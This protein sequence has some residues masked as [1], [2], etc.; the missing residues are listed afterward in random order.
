MATSSGGI[1]HLLALSIAQAASADVE[2]VVVPDEPE[3]WR[4][5]IAGTLDWG[6]GVGAEVLPH[7]EA[8]NLRPI[9]ALA[10]AR[11]PN[12]P[13][14]PTLTEA[15][16]PVSFNLWRG[17]MGPPALSEDD[18]AAWHKTIAAVR[19]TKAWRTYLQRNGQTDDFLAGEPFRVFLEQEWDWFEKHYALAGLLPAGSAPA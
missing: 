1:N 16:A 15:G 5:I 4:R 19:D 6:S 8:G 12:F 14:I 7:I 3:V 13:D 9:A 2:F 11:L 10:E 18:Q 17:L